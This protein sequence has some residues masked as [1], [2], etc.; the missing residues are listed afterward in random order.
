MICI[1]EHILSIQR[2]LRRKG[3]CGMVRG[4]NSMSASYPY[5]GKGFI[6]FHFR[7]S[8]KEYSPMYVVI[9]V[10]IDPDHYAMLYVPEIAVLLL[11][12]ICI[13]TDICS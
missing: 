11:S 12:F 10:Y 13:S 9:H 8:E 6:T 5:R 2:L 1:T 3:L 7:F 4:M